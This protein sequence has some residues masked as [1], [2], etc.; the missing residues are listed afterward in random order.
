M[1]NNFVVYVHTLPNG[2]SYVGYLNLDSIFANG[3]TFDKIMERGE[4]HSKR[5]DLYND[6]QECGWENVQTEIIS[7]LTKEQAVEK[8]KELCI[9]YQ[10]YV[11]RF[12]YNRYTD[13]GLPSPSKVDKSP[14]GRLAKKLIQTFLHNDFMFYNSLL[15]I[16]ESYD[17][18][19]IDK[20]RETVKREAGYI[21]LSLTRKKF[22]NLFS[23]ARYLL[24]VLEDPYSIMTGNW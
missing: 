21:A 10:S 4:Y 3:G 14:K 18:E 11:P 22:N 9:E 20:M 17:D 13:A 24:K 1:E 6:I 23:E 2:K 16:L 12:G 19:T 15:K 5:T 8:K 7:G